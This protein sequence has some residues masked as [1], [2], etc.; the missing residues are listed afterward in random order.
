[1]GS[2]WSQ[3]RGDLEMGRSRRRRRGDLIEA[4]AIA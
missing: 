3:Q 4:D 2:G 1:M